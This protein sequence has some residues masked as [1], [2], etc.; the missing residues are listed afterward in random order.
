M[1][2]VSGSAAAS[3]SL[4]VV[5]ARAAMRWSTHWNC[6]LLPGRVMS[7]AYQTRS[8]TAKPLTSGPIARTVPTAS[9]PRITGV[10]PSALARRTR[11][12]VSTGFTATAATSTSRSFGPGAGRGRSRS[13]SDSEAVMG[14]DWK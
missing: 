8:P 3:A 2:A 9:Q 7:P 10:V 11:I 5:G 1:I 14:N 6:A 13:S 4:T 12:L